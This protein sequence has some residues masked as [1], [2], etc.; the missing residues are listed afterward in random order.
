[1]RLTRN[2]AIWAGLTVVGLLAV[3]V[4]HGQDTVDRSTI[5]PAV[6][7]TAEGGG[8]VRKTEPKGPV[9][10][11]GARYVHFWYT[12]GHWLEWTIEGAAAG[13]Y[14]VTVHYAGKHDVSRA[15]AVNGAPVKA[16]ESFTL[17]RTGRWR[18]W[19]EA[20]LPA[21]VSLRA[22]RN[23]LRMTCLDK[24]SV[25]FREI[26]LSSA[27]KNEIAV[28]AADFSGEGGGKVQVLTSPTQGSV[29]RWDGEG[30]WLEWT[31]ASAP[32][33]RYR[34]E[35]HYSADGFCPL[36]LQVNGGSV[37]GLE[38]FIPPLTGDDVHW[39]I[40]SLPVPVTL[41]EGRNVLRLT[42]LGGK[43]RGVPAFGGRF[44][45]SVIRL[46]RMPAGAAVGRDVLR[47]RTVAEVERTPEK[48]PA[49]PPAPLGP[50]L[51][52]VRNAV[53]LAEGQ[54]FAVAGRSVTI[55]KADV[56]PYVENKFSKRFVFEN[57]DNPELHRLREEYNFE[58]VIAVGKDEFE[59]QVR[60]MKWVY[61][62]WDFG[63]AQEL[64]NLRDPFEILDEAKKGRKFQCMH[65]GA[66]LLTTANS[67]GWVCRPMGIPK[68]TFSE[69]WSNQHRKWIMFDAT[70]NYYPEKD[71]VPLNTYEHRQALLREGGGVMRAWMGDDGVERKPQRDSYGRRL[72][73]IGYIPNTDFLLRGP[74]YGNDKFFITKDELCEGRSWH[75]RD[76]PENPAVAPYFPINQAALALVPDGG[77]VKVTI[78]TMT[79][80]F[81]E[82]QVRLDGGAWQQSDNN[83]VWT[84]RD[85][86]NTL[87]ARSVNL[88][89]VEGPVSTVVLEAKK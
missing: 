30:H 55:T 1:M 21:T 77:N 76:C 49:I 51:P 47:L 4:C 86:T 53:P 32:A 36:T 38:A 35:L 63:H 8:E 10:R 71:G 50:P 31:V 78:G 17:A 16:L 29:T 54:R 33:G 75:T 73:F 5:L 87:E 19:G 27:G 7:F 2:V 72:L 58:K 48:A 61:D 45:L 57:Y 14:K 79:P 81:K 67:L 68:H 42:T 3:R 44:G 6:S 43:R 82:F 37:K 89:G 12:P 52:E 28:D 11:P 66:V 46:V 26:R 25:R 80:N 23:V 60:L 20:T 84:L 69:I 59:K 62:Q 13:D 56:L 64:Y 83:L 24:A 9:D 70:S 65:S 88:F 18:T 74:D 40:G 22:G 85:G 34:V 39:T 15:L 41:K